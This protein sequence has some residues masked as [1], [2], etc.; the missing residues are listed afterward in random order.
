[1]PARPAPLADVDLRGDPAALRATKDEIVDVTFATAD[2]AI[3]SEVGAN[4][5]TV[6]DA[7]LRGAT[8]DTWSVART[9]FDGKYEPLPGT[10][11]G[12]PGRYRNRPS[13]VLA[14][15]MDAP[16]AILRRPSGDRLDGAAGDWLVEYAPGDHGVV[17]AARFAAVYRPTA[18]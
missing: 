16:F 2:G 7:L 8:G 4:R 18:D 12:E 5:Y 10:A 9:I 6:G 11:R 1:V 13:V 17:A 15:R 14:K 3:T